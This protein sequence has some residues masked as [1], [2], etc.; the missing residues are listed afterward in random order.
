MGCL[1]FH[2]ITNTY[3]SDGIWDIIRVIRIKYGFMR[4]T[5]QILN[6]ALNTLETRNI[7][8]HSL[9]FHMVGCVTN[10]CSNHKSNVLYPANSMS[11]HSML[12]HFCLIMGI[13]CQW[14]C[15]Y[16]L[17]FMCKVCP[18]RCINLYKISIWK[19]FIC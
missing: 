8:C 17:L 12:F 7:M 11:K 5:I 6:T 13:F 9:G 2:F 1:I 18:K 4:V 10:F 16:D 14:K 19:P 3:K 15:S